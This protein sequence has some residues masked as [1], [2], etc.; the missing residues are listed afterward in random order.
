V[1]DARHL[2]VRRGI[3]PRVYSESGQLLY[4][5][6]L[7]SAEFVQDVGVVAYGRELDP[8]LIKRI[9]V[10]PEYAYARPLIVEAVGVV[11]PARTGVY[12]SEADAE[13][14]LQALSQYDFF[15]RYAVIFLIN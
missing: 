3:S 7:A 6:V 4:G 14:I 8:D 12:V 9:Q 11:D 2:D 15:A 1:V 5:G 10:D 13:R